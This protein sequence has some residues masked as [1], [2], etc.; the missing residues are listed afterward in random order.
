MRVVH[1]FLVMLSAIFS[2]PCSAR[3]STTTVTK[4]H[5]VSALL[6]ADDFGMAA[7]GLV[8]FDVVT[9]ATDGLVGDTASRCEVQLRWCCRS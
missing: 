2:P 6:L 5:G 1:I 3:I 9:I 8:K 7:G 4:T